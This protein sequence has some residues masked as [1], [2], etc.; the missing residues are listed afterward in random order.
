VVFAAGEVT[1]YRGTLRGDPEM[2]KRFSASLRASGILKGESKFYVSLA[3]DERDV[4]QT[5][6]AFATAIAAAAK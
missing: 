2:H 6:D 5:L 1:D 3:H 4:G